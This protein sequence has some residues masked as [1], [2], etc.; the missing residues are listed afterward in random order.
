[1]NATRRSLEVFDNV[2]EYVED[3]K[4]RLQKLIRI[5]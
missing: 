5:A 4:S 1:M 3:G 2:M